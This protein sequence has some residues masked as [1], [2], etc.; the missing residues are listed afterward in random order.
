MI[1][2]A[3]ARIQ[4]MPR[5]A[6]LTSVRPDR[7]TGTGA[8][9]VGR[10]PDRD[11]G[12][13]RAICAKLRR[14]HALIHIVVLTLT[15]LAAARYIRGVQ[16]NSAPAAVAVAIVFSLFNWLLGGL[17]HVLLFLPAILTLG[18]LF[19]VMPLIVNAILLWLT[20]KALHVFEIEDA[21]GLWLMSLL[22]TAVNA[23]THLALH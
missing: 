2:N 8:R 13:R 9:D 20:D 23:I 11:T 22:I 16:I 1:S 12:P 6:M 18:L 15:V 5:R 7:G 3:S 17:L 19:L 10:A 4:I 21:K 14:M